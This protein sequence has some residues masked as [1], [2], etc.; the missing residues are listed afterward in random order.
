MISDVGQACPHL[1]S[2]GLYF[3]VIYVSQ[4]IN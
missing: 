1:D 3:S 2:S 4:L